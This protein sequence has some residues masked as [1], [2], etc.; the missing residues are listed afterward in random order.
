MLDISLCMIVRNEVQHLERCLASVRGLAGEII[1]GDTG[2]DDG[3][4]DVALRFGAQVIPVVWENDFAKARNAV[5][6]HASRSWILV[7][8][9][10]EQADGWDPAEV[11]AL[12]ADPR[13]FGYY[14]HV[15]SYVGEPDS[16]EY[17]TDSVCRLFRNDPRI[18]FRGS[19]HEE[20]ASCIEEMPGSPLAFSRLIIRHY[21]YTQREIERKNK[22]GRNLA[23]IRTA[24]RQTPGDPLL[25]YALGTEYF[26][27]ENYPAAVR[28]LLPLLAETS[29]DRGY[30]SDLFA[31]CAYSLYMLREDE[32]ALSI[33]ESGLSLYADFSDLHELR[34][35]VLIRQGKLVQA[36]GA[37]EAALHCGDVSAR[38]SSTSGCGTY[39]THY[40]AGQ[41]WD[42]LL[43][44]AEAA[45]HYERALS[46]RPG[47]LPA[48]T[49]LVPLH[50]LQERSS[51]LIALLASYPEA[52][53]PELMTILLPSALNAR[54]AEL[55]SYLHDACKNRFDGVPLLPLLE[56]IALFLADKDDAAYAKLRDLL[57]EAPAD[58]ALVRYGWAAAWKRQRTEQARE[59]ARLFGG[60]RLLRIQ[61]CLEERQNQIDGDFD[62]LPAWQALVQIGAWDAALR[63]YRNANGA[64]RPGTAP[65]SIVSGM[66]QAPA[67]YRRQW[68]RQYEALCTEEAET[69][70]PI[71]ASELL[72][73]T[74]LALSCGIKPDIPVAGLARLCADR[75]GADMALACY[76]IAKAAFYG[77]LPDDYRDWR[78]LFRVLPARSDEQGERNGP[79]TATP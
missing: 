71:H 42:R 60:D 35:L 15:I 49:E 73:Y 7:L 75:L 78:Q 76:R 51:R 63:L 72:L 13:I 4:V 66:L 33:I 14:V 70:A 62:W 6:R 22:M 43:R 26:Q 20:A 34:A 40:L 19:I 16:R 32:R 52:L 69:K 28:T 25:R 45:S 9:A 37:L 48:W 30:L 46:Y 68:C 39:R 2:S 41:V 44:F 47:Y 24:L 53:S 5:L 29:T 55:V 50:L 27:A 56:T 21:G 3:T 57:R 36:L 54:S 79:A 10:D 8:D 1:V 61:I 59:I 74:I 38:Y 67:A 77:R 65:P 17:V 23:L 18:R 64:I 31:K 11:A 58:P 12:L